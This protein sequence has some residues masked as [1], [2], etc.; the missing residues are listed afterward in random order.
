MSVHTATHAEK[1]PRALERA[2]E[3]V[4][5]WWTSY[6]T[7][8]NRYLTAAM[9]QAAAAQSAPPTSQHPGRVDR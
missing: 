4:S 5:D 7:L 9:L 1:Q 6:V 8:H 3:L 2:A